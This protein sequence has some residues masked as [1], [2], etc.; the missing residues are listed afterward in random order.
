MVPL[1]LPGVTKARKI[2]KIGMHASDTGL[3]H[4]EDVR[5]PRWHL[6]GEEGMG[7]TYQML[8]LSS[9]VR[10]PT[11]QASRSSWNCSIW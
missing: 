6:I 1:D 3:L 4:F 7:F 11:P 10:H 9:W 5:V 2:D 8:Q